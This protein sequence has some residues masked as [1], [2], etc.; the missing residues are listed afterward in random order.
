M[1]KSVQPIFGDNGGNYDVG[2][3]GFCYTDN[4]FISQGIAWFTR[5]DKEHMPPV[6]H[7]FIVT[8]SNSCIEAQAK[9][10]VPADLTQYFNTP[11]V[12]VFFRKPVGWTLDLGNKIVAK[13]ASKIGVRYNFASIIT[14]LIAGSTIGHY[15]NKWF[16]NWP[17]KIVSYSVGWIGMVCSTF[18]A[19]TLQQ[20]D[21][22][23]LLGCLQLPARIITPQQLADDDTLFVPM[24][25]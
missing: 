10:V 11:H 7:T 17:N 13:G 9:G 15:L 12:H 3:V 21:E 25:T 23:K 20:F 1:I 19:W 24:K 4:S 22:F 5:W 8:G 2:Y 18:V 6:S 14:D 16:N